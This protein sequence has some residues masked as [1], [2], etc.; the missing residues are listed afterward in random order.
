MKPL[1]PPQHCLVP[2]QPCAVTV[3]LAA[4][5]Q[6][7]IVA[8]VKS[9]SDILLR[10]CDRAQ[11]AEVVPQHRGIHQYV[12]GGAVQGA[13]LSELAPPGHNDGPGIHGQGATGMDTYQQTG[14]IGQ[15]LK[16]VKFKPE[17]PVHE[18]VP[19]AGLAFHQFGIW[20]IQTL[21]WFVVGNFSRL[22]DRT[23]G[24]LFR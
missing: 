21:P 22:S 14:L 7:H 19:D 2:I 5:P 9:S 23:L 20:T 13:C 6:D 12:V 10:R 15:I 24:R 8:F 11:A 3:H 18:E 1:R 17:V 16:A 4:G